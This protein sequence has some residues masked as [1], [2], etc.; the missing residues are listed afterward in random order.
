MVGDPSEIVVYQGYE[1]LE[2][3]GVAVTMRDEKLCDVSLVQG[4]LQVSRLARCGPEPRPKVYIRPLQGQ[5]GSRKNV[6]RT[7][8]VPECGNYGLA[9]GRSIF[10]LLAESLGPRLDPGVFH[11]GISEEGKTGFKL[12]V[13]LVGSVRID[14]RSCQLDP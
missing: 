14:Q 12:V 8:T 13:G 10:Q 1:L 4:R 7:A 9:A 6:E 2:G 3:L 11:S 5:V